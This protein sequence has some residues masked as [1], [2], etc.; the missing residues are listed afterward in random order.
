MSSHALMWRVTVIQA[1]VVF[2]SGVT[3]DHLTG[4]IIAIIFLI[5]NAITHR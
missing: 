2:I 1:I 3:V 5:T 4:A